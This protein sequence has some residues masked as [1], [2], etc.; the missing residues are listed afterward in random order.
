MKIPL[1]RRILSVAFALALIGLIT[2]FVFRQPSRNISPVSTQPAADADPASPLSAIGVRPSPALPSGSAAPVLPSLPPP[3]PPAIVTLSAAPANDD[4][5]PVRIKATGSVPTPAAA[6]ASEP[7][8]LREEKIW[9]SQSFLDI[10]TRVRNGEAVPD[11]LEFPIFDGSSLTFTGLRYHRLDSA[12]EGIFTARVKGDPGGGHVLFS[13]VNH[14][15]SGVIHAP[16]SGLALSIR[17]ATPQGGESSVIY[18]AQ[19]DPE[20]MPVCGTCPRAPAAGNPQSSTLK[21]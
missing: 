16:E 20:K 19:L 21:P 10:G 2:V 17:N 12:N 5:Y 18:L 9:L 8:K 3:A 11:E 15:L 7:W 4:G 14:A 6:L 1:Q 13:Y